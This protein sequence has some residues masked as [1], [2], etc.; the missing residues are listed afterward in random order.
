MATVGVVTGAGRGMGAA[1]AR[2]L[3]GT[4]DRLILVDLDA[5]ALDEAV[6]GLADAKSPD[7]AAETSFEPLAADVTDRDGVARIASLARESGTLRAVAHAAGI[8]PGMA[9]WRRVLGVDL[10]GTA[11]LLEELLPLA[12]P[13]TAVVCFASMAGNFAPQPMDPA[14]AAALDAP[15]APDFV[16]RLRAAVGADLE[17]PGL[18]Y[19]WAKAGVQRLARRE[20]ARWGAAGG[21]ICSVSPG[22]IDTRQTQLESQSSSAIEGLFRQCALGRLGQPEE[23]AEVV[24]FLLSDA[25]RYVTGVD[26]LVDGGVVAGT[27]APP[28]ASGG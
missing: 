20:A 27:T 16:D 24:G 4:V 14:A 8:S 23:V 21:R 9:D 3:T 22:L 7:G 17:N 26:L 11:L 15:L 18:A 25:A 19:T 28:I 12:A 6:A 5:E 1:C 2:R 13:G 10:V